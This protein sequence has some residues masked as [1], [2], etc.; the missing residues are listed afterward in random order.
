MKAQV[1]DYV[2][3]TKYHDGDT[4]D[5]YCVGFLSKIDGD[6]FHVVDN[7]RKSFRAN[8]FRRVERITGLE[9]YYLVNEIFPNLLPDGDLSIWEHLELIRL[10]EERSRS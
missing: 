5:H 8:G 3:A 1:G 4:G 10:R 7:S 6:R 9:G 2:L